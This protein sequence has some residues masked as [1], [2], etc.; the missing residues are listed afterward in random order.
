[1]TH[2]ED[3]WQSSLL[4]VEQGGVIQG[5]P[6]SSYNYGV[7][8]LPLGERVKAEHPEVASQAI[9]DNW[10]LAVRLKDCTKAPETIC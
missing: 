7:G 2:F 8:L 4:L 5:D 3:A 10:A 9:A 6:T 1:M